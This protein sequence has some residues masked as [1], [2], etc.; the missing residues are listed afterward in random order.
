MTA[1]RAQTGLYWTRRRPITVV[2][3]LSGCALISG[4]KRSEPRSRGH[5]EPC[6][7]A[8]ICHYSLTTSR[9]GRSI[10]CILTT[11]MVG[12]MTFSLSLITGIYVQ[13]ALRQNVLKSNE[14]ESS[15]KQTAIAVSLA[16]RARPCIW[17]RDSEK[18]NY[19]IFSVILIVIV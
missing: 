19:S 15:N 10:T 8:E 6:H 1:C 11:H 5:R 18:E 4:T 3:M 14:D 13:N 7:Q 17:C 16:C 12:F 2:L 9:P